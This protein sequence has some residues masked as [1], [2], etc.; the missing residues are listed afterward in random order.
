MTHEPLRRE[1]YGEF[2]EEPGGWCWCI[3]KVDCRVDP[4]LASIIFPNGTS[5]S[6]LC[7]TIGRARSWCRS[8]LPRR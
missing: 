3:S 5:T 2:H 7:P 6:G 8:L 1:P 4:Y